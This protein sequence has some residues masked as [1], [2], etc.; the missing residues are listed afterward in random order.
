MCIVDQL[1]D[2]LVPIDCTKK[3]A[4]LIFSFGRIFSELWY[5]HFGH[6]LPLCTT[7]MAKHKSRAWADCSKSTEQSPEF[8]LQRDSL[9]TSI[10]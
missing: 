7:N 2:T 1:S 4:E 10:A 5:I 8:E 9:I 6:G 3:C